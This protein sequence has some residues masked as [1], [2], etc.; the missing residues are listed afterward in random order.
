[1]RQIV[2]LSVSSGLV[3][4][5]VVRLKMHFP[6][7]LKN[8]IGSIDERRNSSNRYHAVFRKMWDTGHYYINLTVHGFS[9][10]T[11]HLFGNFSDRYF[12][13]SQHL[14][15]PFVPNDSFNFLAVL[16]ERNENQDISI[17][18]GAIDNC[19]NKSDQGAEQY[20]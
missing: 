9:D 18:S 1:M 3:S 11:C 14:T 16:Y 19:V 6:N 8:C 2:L 20:S 5:V 12:L 13:H 17:V 15:D 7:E 4:V 10:F